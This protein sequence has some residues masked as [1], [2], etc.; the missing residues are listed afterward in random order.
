MK[1]LLFLCILC[2]VLVACSFH[3]KQPVDEGYY[4]KTQGVAWP[5]S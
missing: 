1:K 2:M 4:K 5:N 3:Q